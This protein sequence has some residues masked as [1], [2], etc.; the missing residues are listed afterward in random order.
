MHKY[1]AKAEESEEPPTPLFS[2]FYPLSPPT[3]SH[4]S[5]I[6][7]AVIDHEDGFLGY[8]R[9]PDWLCC[10]A[11]GVLSVLEPVQIGEI[12]T[13]RQ[14]FAGWIIT[15]TDA[16]IA[17]LFYLSFQAVGGQI[18]LYLVKAEGLNMLKDILTIFLFR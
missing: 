2:L 17:A 15:Q 1:G 7:A 3:L 6:P 18:S 16:E 10:Q 9:L 11:V 13:V 4:K 5:A 8:E 14:V 12:L